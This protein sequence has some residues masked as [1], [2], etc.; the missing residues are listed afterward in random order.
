MA[1]V[2]HGSTTV[3][4]SSVVWA[5]V[6]E[7]DWLYVNGVVGII[8]SVNGDQ[9][10]VT[11]KSGWAGD[12]AY[13]V[14]YVILK[15][16]WQRYEPALTQA[17][18]RELLLFLSGVGFFYA[19]FG[20]TPDDSVGNDGDFALKVNVT[21]WKMWE[22]IAGTW[23]FQG[24]PVGINW[25]T[26]GWNGVTAYFINDALSRLGRSYIAIQPNTNQPPESSPTYW[27][28]LAQGG[29]RYDVALWASSRPDS[30]EH[31][32]KVAI[33]TAVT[34]YTNLSDS[35]AKCGTA[36]S[37]D[38]VF[39]IQKNG[40]QFAT[41]TFHNG[42]STGVFTNVADVVFAAGDLLGIIAPNPRDAT[43]ADISVTLTGFR[44]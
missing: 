8:D 1:S 24:V 39:S 13:D 41:L 44:G 43:L 35:A 31:A 40:S 3:Q 32:L 28:I 12:S 15:N 20:T 34:F 17:K 2:G 21:P 9:D 30:G 7:G 26:G 10:E 18:L 5:D 29:D 14:N 27:E 16:S 22:K 6:I 38:A 19:V 11:L 23:V 36:A 25:I 42:S 33:P 37:A 4:G